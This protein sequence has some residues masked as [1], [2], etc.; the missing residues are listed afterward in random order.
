MDNPS[1]LVAGTL[2]NASYSWIK[3]LG[4]FAPGEGKNRVDFFREEGIDS[5]PAKVYE[6][7]YPE[8]NR[9]VIYSVKKNG[10]SATWAV[11]DGRWV[12][13][14]QNPSWTLPLMNAY[15]VKT[16]STWPREFPA[17][18]KVQLAFFESRGV[19]SPFGNP[20][21]GNAHVVDLDT[22]RA[23]LA[24]QDE[25][26]KAT[27]H[28]LQLVKIDPRVWKYSLAVSL[29][30]CALLVALPNAWAEARIIAGIVFGMA[31]CTGLLPYVAPI[32]TTPRH[33]LAK[34]QYL[35]LERAPKYGKRTGRR[36][37]G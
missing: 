18:E 7:A 8:P 1:A 25:P 33:G 17:P 12:E 36:M 11:L 10:F 34:K 32:I 16:N 23:I 26:E 19:T 9:I 24:F 21:F 3:Q 30:S 4:L 20:E 35:P 22:I 14:V 13:S 37:L 29:P 31:A 15:G 27:I 6:R 28:D 5:I 2:N